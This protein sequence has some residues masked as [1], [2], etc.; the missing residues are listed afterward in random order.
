MTEL[1]RSAH[2]IFKIKYHLVFCIKYRKDLF[3]EEG[4][5][6]IGSFS[7]EVE[8]DIHLKKA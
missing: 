4:R 5:A 8:P 3:L 6:I 7:K 2:K 1:I